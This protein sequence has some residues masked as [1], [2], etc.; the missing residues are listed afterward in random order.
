MTNEAGDAPNFLLLLPPAPSPPS[1]SA[2]RAAYR[3]TLVQVLKEVAAASSESS[4]GAILEIALAC[5]HLVDQEDRPNSEIYAET[6]TVIAGLYKLICVVAAQEKINVEGAD[7]VDVRILIVSWSPDQ[8]DTVRLPIGPIV[9]LQT[10]ANSQRPWQYAFGVESAEGEAFVKA[11]VL[12]KQSRTEVYHPQG[13]IAMSAQTQADLQSQSMGTVKRHNHVAVGG[14]FDH[15]HIGHKL[16]LTMTAL[17]VDSTTFENQDQA[18]SL[19]IGITGDELLKNKKYA[20]CLESWHDRQKAVWSFLKAIIDFA[21]PTN[22]QNINIE[23]VN[24]QGPNGHAVNIFI[25][26]DFVVKCVEI[27]DPFGPTITNE[28]ISALVISAETR[29]GGKAVNDKR[30]EKGWAELEVFEVDVLDAG[31]NDDGKVDETFQ[32]KISSTE[33]RRAL[34]QKK[35]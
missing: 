14:T 30:K 2:L 33:I 22:L 32:S 25:A 17:C 23:E 1:Q 19:T 16:L 15:L 20:E 21:P 13:G 34:A 3:E 27:W 6:Q 7:G 35:K 29:S 8:S 26:P 5:P 11:F 4:N 12:A 31:A 28:E 18:R 24:G 10:L 9:D